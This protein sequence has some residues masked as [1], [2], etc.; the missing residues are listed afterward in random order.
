M[1][2]PNLVDA[3][4]RYNSK[5]YESL[6]S[7]LLDSEPN[8]NNLQPGNGILQDLFLWAGL[9]AGKLW[10]VFLDPLSTKIYNSALEAGS[11]KFSNHRE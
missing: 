6:N 5:E 4:R 8:S 10:P 2:T 11:F 1:R 9:R 3:R 7:P